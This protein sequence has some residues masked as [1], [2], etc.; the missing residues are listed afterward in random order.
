[1]QLESFA[2]WII[3]CLIVVY[4]WRRK[5]G[6]QQDN[7]GTVVQSTCF[8]PRRNPQTGAITPV[9]QVVHTKYYR[10]RLTLRVLDDSDDEEG[11][12]V[13][14]QQC[15]TLPSPL[16][17]APDV[18]HNATGLPTVPEEEGSEYDM[19]VRRMNLIL[20]QDSHEKASSVSQQQNNAGHNPSPGPLYVNLVAKPPSSLTSL[21][22][23]P[24]FN[25]SS[26]SSGPPSDIASYCSESYKNLHHRTNK[27]GDEPMDRLDED[28]DEDPETGENAW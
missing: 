14:Q 10:I 25:W 17:Q 24:S 19:W 26:S 1:M 23:G 20:L 4:F 22:S 16:S 27:A 5:K 6:H 11:G 3:V 2:F 21:S 15:D 13:S 18:G 8:V 12:D 7:R 28:F 9:P